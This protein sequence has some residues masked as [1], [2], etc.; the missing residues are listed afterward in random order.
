MTDL[1]CEQNNILWY[2]DVAKCPPAHCGE[3]NCMFSIAVIIN[4]FA[5]FA[6]DLLC[7]TVLLSWFAKKS[8]QIHKKGPSPTAGR[9]I[10][11]T[12][13]HKDDDDFFNGGRLLEDAFGHPFFSICSNCFVCTKVLLNF[14][15]LF[16]LELCISFPLQKL[17]HVGFFQELVAMTTKTSSRTLSECRALLAWC[18]ETTAKTSKWEKTLSTKSIKYIL[19][20]SSWTKCTHFSEYD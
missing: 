14:A 4:I 8:S 11:E 13:D 17:S 15:S 7:H 16:V 20:K 5:I 1:S 9:F 18:E 19:D 3:P 6:N 10:T 12:S 2:V